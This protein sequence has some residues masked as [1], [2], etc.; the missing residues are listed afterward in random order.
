MHT[1]V[2]QGLTY[3]TL[4]IVGAISQIWLLWFSRLPLGVRDEWVWSRVS[5]KLPSLIDCLPAIITGLLLVG[6][7]AWHNSHRE[8]PVRTGWWLTGL[9]FLGLCWSVAVISASP[10]GGG[11]GRSVFVIFY[12]RTSGYFHQALYEAEDLSQFL[13]EYEEGISDKADPDNYLH[14]GTHPPGLTASYR[15]L[16]EL[17]E[18]SPAL[19]KLLMSSQPKSV[20]SAINFIQQQQLLS[21]KEFTEPV[22]AALWLSIVISHFLAVLTVVPLYFLATRLASKETARFIATYWLFVPAVLIF[23]P[24]SDASFPCLAMFLQLLWLKALERNSYFYGSL[25]AILFTCCA[26]L[27]LAFVTIGVVLFLQMLYY[28]VKFK[29]GWKPTVS[30]LLTGLVFVFVMNHL[31][32][33]NLFTIWLQNFQ[34]HGRFYDHNTRSYISWLFVNPI[35]AGVAIGLP[36]GITA[37]FGLMTLIGRTTSTSTTRERVSQSTHSLARRACRFFSIVRLSDQNRERTWVLFGLLIWSILWISG[38]NMG[39][40]ARLWIFLMPYAVLVASFSIETL[41]QSKSKLV[42]RYIPVAVLAV[43]AVVCFL[44]AIQIDGFG[45]TEL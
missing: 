34:N 16:I 2:R 10:A 13:H 5:E 23:L 29:I 6:Y 28:Q 41:M 31:L 38:K 15:L 8:R 30:G 18:R 21:G 22:A 12:P 4:I 44:T 32:E 42:S 25:T 20:S 14:I 40:A 37:L 11:M 9:V 26:S 27:S 17:C 33:M 7:A 39:E 3:L 35:E 45:F 36:L 24:K 43:Q 1:N 19:T